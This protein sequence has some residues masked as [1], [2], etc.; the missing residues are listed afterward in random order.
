MARPGSGQDSLSVDRGLCVLSR[1]ETATKR[2]CR[3]LS[4]G[5]WCGRARSLLARSQPPL[6]GGR[7]KT[8]KRRWFILTDN[9]LY[10]FEYTTVS[11]GGPDPPLPPPP[12]RRARPGSQRSEAEAEAGRVL[13][14]Q[15]KEPRGIIPLE[16]LSIREVEDP[17]KS[18]SC[19][20]LPP[21]P[22]PARP[23]LALR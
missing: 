20:L 16:N 19:L 9:C 5:S 21:P 18:V 1:K 4:D 13:S 22:P 15:D 14:P 10:Y 12:P 6:A 11:R 7:V 17:R 8:W 2:G 3:C 23:A